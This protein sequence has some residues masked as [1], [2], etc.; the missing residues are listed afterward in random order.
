MIEKMTSERQEVSTSAMEDNAEGLAG[1]GFGGG[2]GSSPR[3]VGAY[4]VREHM[5]TTDMVRAIRSI[6]VGVLCWEEAP[7]GWPASITP[8]VALNLTAAHR[9][10]RRNSPELDSQSFVPRL[11]E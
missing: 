10:A 6:L 8:A 3:V 2:L 11:I 1:K 7:V 4:T 5:S 9:Q